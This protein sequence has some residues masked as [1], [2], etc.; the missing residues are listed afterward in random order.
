MVT[1]NLT[2]TF[3][4]STPIEG[5]GIDFS[6]TNNLT[7]VSSAQA[8]RLLDEIRAQLTAGGKIQ[9]GYLTLN[10][11][12]DKGEFTISNQSRF[13]NA[14]NQKQAAELVKSLVQ[15]AY[16]EAL[17]ETRSVQLE[18]SID[19][20]LDAKRGGQKM[21]TKSFVKLLNQ[22]ELATGG[23]ALSEEKASKGSLTWNDVRSP[24]F[25]AA[26][27]DTSAPESPAKTEVKDKP[28]SV[29][30]AAAQRLQVGESISLETATAAGATVG[31]GAKLPW[32]GLKVIGGGVDVSAEGMQQT[33]VMLKR[34]DDGFVL[35]NRDFAGWGGS[36]G[37]EAHAVMELGNLQKGMKRGELNAKEYKFSSAEDALKF[38]SHGLSGMTASHGVAPGAGEYQ[39]LKNHGGFAT[40]SEALV[41]HQ[42]K[43]RALNAKPAG[44]SGE[45]GL[46][47]HQLKVES[48]RIKTRDGGAI[49]HHVYTD[50][51]QKNNLFLKVFSKVS[52]IKYDKSTITSDIRL[53]MHHQS[54]RS[55][56]G[57]TLIHEFAPDMRL[58]IDS[59]IVLAC[60]DR[61][62]VY[63]LADIQFDRT[64]YV[65]EK[66][67]KDSPPG[68][69]DLSEEGKQA[70]KQSIYAGFN[71]IHK[72]LTEVV[73]P[74]Q[75]MANP[76]QPTV[77]QD[78]RLTTGM[79]GVKV[80]GT[81]LV[82]SSTSGGMVSMKLAFEPLREPL[83]DGHTPM[84]STADVLMGYSTTS[85]QRFD[86]S[87]GFSSEDLPTFL[88]V[89]AAAELSRGSTTLNFNVTDRIRADPNQWV[90]V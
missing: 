83:A 84:R 57:D 6:K 90:E 68:C 70:L 16:G 37:A 7:R 55:G 19:E 54:E 3:I 65:M 41:R 9:S 47:Q 69:F 2:R 51:H 48:T 85:M 24:D 17:G 30:A 53:E 22:L 26:F 35:S 10:Q 20:Y 78:G 58:G 43:A 5:R 31:A 18:R 49:G 36:I 75:R 60:R 40:R 46:I 50:T 38:L 79:G 82:R 80:L 11:A 61:E 88:D 12:D 27:I 63:E 25:S 62:A 8:H 4:Q 33:N 67:N 29:I 72:K 15:I 21:G 32:P 14:A 52:P 74:A 42:T 73:D 56:D 44:G 81:G 39:V 86:L 87:L 76:A 1:T 64:V 66:A 34:V 71:H 23:Y 28:L 13:G 77:R 59:G 89:K 45:T